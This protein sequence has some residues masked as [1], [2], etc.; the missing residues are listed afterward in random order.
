MEQQTLNIQKRD[1]FILM[2]C[3]NSDYHNSLHVDAAFLIFRKSNEAI[4]FVEKWLYYCEI[5]DI[6]VGGRNSAETSKYGS[7]LPQFIQHRN[8]QSVLGN[9]IPANVFINLD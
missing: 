4:K 2:D 7:E 5:P 8:D 3:D 9:G 6:I 1:T